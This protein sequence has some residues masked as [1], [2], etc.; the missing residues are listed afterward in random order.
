MTGFFPNLQ[1]AANSTRIEKSPHEIAIVRNAQPFASQSFFGRGLQKVRQQILTFASWSCTQG[2]N[3]ISLVNARGNFNQNQSVPP[4]REQERSEAPRANREGLPGKTQ[5]TS[6]DFLWHKIC[7]ISR[8]IQMANVDTA[9]AHLHG[10][11]TKFKEELK[12][13]IELPWQHLP[14]LNW[15]QM[16]MSLS[17]FCSGFK[18]QWFA[19]VLLLKASHT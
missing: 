2:C 5:M 13:L 16:Q 6:R 10:V 19:A 1:N 12:Q 4:V 15:M 7:N 8:C 3:K 17:F 18:S 9:R 14:H 11:K